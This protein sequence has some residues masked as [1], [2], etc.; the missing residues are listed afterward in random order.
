MLEQLLGQLGFTDK[1]ITVYLCVLEHGK[2]SAAAVA[3]ITKVNRTTVYS[4][5]KELITKGVITEDIGGTNRYYT[6][7]PPEELRALYRKE[8]GE[9]IEKKQS[10]EQLITELA[11]L[12][13]NKSYSVPKIRFIDESL[14]ADFLHK[15][16]PTW[17][18]SAKSTDKNWWGFQDTSFIDEYPEWFKYHWQIFP[19]DYGTRLFT[20]K[21]PSEEKFAEHVGDEDRR[22][23]KYWAKSKDFTAT[24]AVLGDYVLFCVTNQHPHYL[25][26]IHDAVMAENLREMFKGMWEE[27]K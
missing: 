13:K 6:A 9:L 10:I 2:L 20:N 27:I 17:I 15:Q 3:R 26:E 4:V 11:S 24:H 12:P 16:L 18:E 7:L 22:Q 8:E 14:L 1:E 23:V 19:N 25:V 21:K 5:S